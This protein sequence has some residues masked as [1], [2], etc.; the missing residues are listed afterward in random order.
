MKVVEKWCENAGL[1][2]NPDKSELV[3]FT[4]NRNLTGFKN[5]KI[6][7]REIIRK[8]S[9]KYLGITLDSKLNWAEHI[10]NTLN[11]GLRIFW[12]C[13]SAI[14]KNGA[15]H[16]K[17]FYGYSNSAPNNYVWRIYMVNRHKD[18]H[19]PQLIEPLAKSDVLGV[20][21]CDEHHITNCNGCIT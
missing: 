17:P 10:E 16:Q 2:V 5:P 6:F 8:N 12:S 13:R 14:G 18:S 4:K 3:I 21:S 19:N 9:V 7:G 15:F 1:S 11:K 20:H